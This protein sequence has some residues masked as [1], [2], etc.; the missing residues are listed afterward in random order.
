MDK[1]RATYR[2]VVIIG[3]AIMASLVVYVAIVGFLEDKKIELQGTP[4]LSGN[5][6]EI[7][8]FVLLGGAGVILFLIKFLSVRILNAGKAQGGMPGPQ[9][10]GTSGI[11]PEFGP[12]VTAAVVTFALCETPAIFGL[13]LYFIGRNTTDFYLFLIVSMFF[14]ATNFPKFSQ[15]EEWYRQRSGGQRRP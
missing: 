1:L 13:V 2:T 15:W 8:K 6:I 10:G 9:A 7:L 4:A 11:S 5:E 3:L 14:F 12:L